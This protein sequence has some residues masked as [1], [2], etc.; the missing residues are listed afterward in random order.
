LWIN[1]DAIS[2]IDL[3]ECFNAGRCANFEQSSVGDP[4]RISRNE[5]L[6]YCSWQFGGRLPAQTELTAAGPQL[7]SQDLANEWVQD[8]NTIKSGES[9][10]KFRCVFRTPS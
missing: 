10:A 5:A 1:R 3:V 7:V 6:L 2:L 4:V 9:I 8:A